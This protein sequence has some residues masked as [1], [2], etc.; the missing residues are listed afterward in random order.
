VEEYS[1]EM[2]RPGGGDPSPQSKGKNMPQKNSYEIE[3]IP[4]MRRFALDSGYLG[5]RRHI[6][7]GLNDGHQ[8]E[9]L[10]IIDEI[11]QLPYNGARG[12]AAQRGCCKARN[13]RR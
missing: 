12:R 9:S 1:R 8:E 6:V 11:T 10:V 2:T 3:P 5:R 7:H 4:R 13:D